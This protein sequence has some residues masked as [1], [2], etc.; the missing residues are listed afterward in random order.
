MA[1]QDIG[2]TEIANGA[3]QLE[4]PGDIARPRSAIDIDPGHTVP[5]PGVMREALRE[6]RLRGPRGV[7]DQVLEAQRREAFRDVEH[8]LADATAGR[9]ADEHNVKRTLMTLHIAST[10]ARR[11]IAPLTATITEY[12]MTNLPNVFRMP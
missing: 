12:G 1:V 10:R 2:A 11:L 6:L 9:L 7:D 4:H 5:V 3:P 8:V